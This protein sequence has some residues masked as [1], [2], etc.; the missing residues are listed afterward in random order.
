MN[1]SG[2]LI[3]YLHPKADMLSA[4]FKK[5][6]LNGTEP[7]LVNADQPMMLNI[8]DGLL[9][10]LQM[11]PSTLSLKEIFVKTDGTNRNEF[12][13][14]ASDSETGPQ[15]EG[16]LGYDTLKMGETAKIGNLYVDVNSMYSPNWNQS[17]GKPKVDFPFDEIDTR[18]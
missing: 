6:K 7:S 11:D 12:S 16:E 9:A 8:H 15:C 14:N 4:E 3:Y 1:V 17:T 13:V 5:M 2:G 18:T 10:Y